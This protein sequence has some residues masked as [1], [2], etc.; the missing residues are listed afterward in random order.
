MAKL[1]LA[2]VASLIVFFP[3]VI[4]AAPLTGAFSIAGLADFRLGPN[5]ID[6]VQT[7]APTFGLGTPGD[8]IFTSGTGSFSGLALTFGKIKDLT[9]PPDTAGV[10]ISEPNFL[11]SAAQ[12]AWDF[13]LRL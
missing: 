7:A 8:I 2:A 12:P 5:F 3:A 1:N 13:T 10:P 4:G 6:W 11:T 9:S